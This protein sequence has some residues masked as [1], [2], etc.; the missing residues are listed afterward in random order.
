MEVKSATQ[1]AFFLNQILKTQYIPKL[2]SSDPD[3]LK[4]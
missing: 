1:T 4:E 3:M 2:H